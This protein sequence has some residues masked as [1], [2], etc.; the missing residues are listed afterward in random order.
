MEMIIDKKLLDKQIKA[1]VKSQDIK[2]DIKDGILNL[3]SDIYN[4]NN[5]PITSICKDDIIQAFEGNNNL[6]D[7]KKRVKS[8]SD[9]EM[10]YFASKLAD[11]YCNQL[12][13]DSVRIIFKDRFMSD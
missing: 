1:I 6:S 7:I 8:M 9:D 3:L 2:Q 12:F 11:D 13:W 10:E 5:F 4:K